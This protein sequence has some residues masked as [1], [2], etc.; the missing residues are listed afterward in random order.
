MI[1]RS[2]VK[3]E[4]SARGKEWMRQYKRALFDYLRSNLR[5]DFTADKLDRILKGIVIRQG[6]YTVDLSFNIS[7]SPDEQEAIVNALATAPHVGEWS[8]CRERF[9]VT[10]ARGYTSKPCIILPTQLPT[11]PQ[12]GERILLLILSKE[13]RANIPG[14]L[15]EEYIQIAVKHT[16]RYAKLWYYKQVAAS[17]WPLL[18]KALRWGAIAWIGELARRFI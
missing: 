11:P 9:T 5:D 7:L 2:D 18:R 12:F 6:R 16:E 4:I 14:D 8:I 1:N 13:E 10:W 3:A 17:A 15:A